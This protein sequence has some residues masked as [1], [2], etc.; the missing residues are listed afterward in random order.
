MNNAT[1]IRLIFL[2]V[3]S[4]L[5]VGA[6]SE[7]PLQPFF[8]PLVVNPAFA[9]LDKVTS[10]R[11]GNQYALADSANSYN[12]FY[13]T[14]DTYSD[15]L[16]GGIAFYFLQGLVG[17]QNISTTE[18]GLSYAGI[19]KKI[20]G[21]TI[22]YGLNTNFLFA[23]KQWS[24]AT[25]DRL[26]VDPLTEPNLPG[27]D[28]YRYTILKPSVS[29]LWDLPDLTWGI[30][31]G[32]YLKINLTEEESTENQQPFHASF[33]LTKNREG[34]RKG[35]H[36][37][38]FVINP[39]IMI[40]YSDSYLLGR[41]NLYTEFTRNTL[42]VFLNGDFFNNVYSLGGIGGLASDNLRLNLAAGAGYS[43]STQ[44]IGFTGELSLILKIPQFDY[45]KF[46][47]W[48]PQ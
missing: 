29:L 14:Y 23:T 24:V 26:M 25:L 37:L 15:K 21:G 3:L 6:Q 12:L 7:S 44:K 16:K 47:P 11:T 45:S 4:T 18:L 13:A 19:A 5:Q 32:S 20:R 2:F 28:L 22:R 30:T 48:Q 46:N 42:G 38:P 39:E 41:L 27:S 10:L 34:Y 43:V 36:T 40:Y 8:N 9:G 35:L 1:K 31:F 33:Y 17:N